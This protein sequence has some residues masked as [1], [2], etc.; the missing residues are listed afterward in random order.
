MSISECDLALPTWAHRCGYTL[1]SGQPCRR[2]V[3]LEGAYCWQHEPGG[4]Q[5]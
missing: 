1:A 2:L 5:K 3:R 4:A